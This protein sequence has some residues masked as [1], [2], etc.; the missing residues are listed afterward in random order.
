MKK[1][2]TKIGFV[3]IITFVFASFIFPNKKSLAVPAPES[4]ICAITGTVLDIQTKK[5]NFEQ[6]RLKRPDFE[7]YLITLSIK[8][9]SIYQEGG[10]IPNFCEDLNGKDK[11][12]ILLKEYKYDKGGTSEKEIPI[13]KGDVINA[14]LK[15]GGDEFLGGYF[16]SFK[17]DIENVS[18]SKDDIKITPTVSTASIVNNK[19]SNLR[20]FL[21]QTKD[22]VISSLKKIQDTV[23]NFFSFNKSILPR[24]FTIEI[25]E[26]LTNEMSMGGASRNY[27]S[28]ITFL[29]NKPVNGFSDY[30]K[31]EGTTCYQDVY[32]VCER[33]YHCVIN[34]GK[35][36]NKIGGGNCGIELDFPLIKK[37]LANKIVS[38]K[39]LQE[40]NDCSYKFFSSCY[41]ITKPIDLDP[42]KV[43]VVENYLMNNHCV[44]NE[45]CKYDKNARL[46]VIPEYI[47]SMNIEY[48][49]NV[50]KE[51]S[52]ED[53]IIE[54]NKI[55]IC[56]NNTCVVH[57]DKTKVEEEIKKNNL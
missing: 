47:K 49:I 18:I 39:S 7:Y 33:Y 13:K 26:D 41:K 44:K 24:S 40:S 37:E 15:T 35:W 14:Y 2:N 56:D 21:I 51:S 48:G 31:K 1:I 6:W 45:D 9:S 43:S 36:V 52:I 5:T 22:K 19:L 29:N 16:L 4:D 28:E 54:A 27:H 12:V 53:K 8:D 38:D 30:Y 55:C 20:D 10:I 46:C 3:L 50:I 25:F 34:D 32:S 11:K 57:L 23:S 17:Q 42:E